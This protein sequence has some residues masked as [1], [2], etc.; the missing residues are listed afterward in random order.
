MAE[1]VAVEA[2]DAGADCAKDGSAGAVAAKGMVDDAGDGGAADADA[3]QGC[4]RV[5]VA[6]RVLFGAVE[7][8]DP[9]DGAGEGGVGDRGGE[10]ERGGMAAP[11]GGI[12][13]I[14]DEI[15]RDRV[16]G[17]A[18]FA[19]FADDVKAGE[20][21]AQRVHDHELRAAIGERLRI[22]G[23]AAGCDGFAVCGLVNCV[24]VAASS[25]VADDATG[26][27]GYGDARR[28]EQ[29]KRN[30]LVDGRGC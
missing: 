1:S 30:A 13:Q 2:C 25:H 14:R 5:E 8:I 16:A 19:F 17:E 21:A 18:H 29:R 3:D 6:E 22:G 12:A 24:E 10:G 11:C 9:H 20:E 27:L 4:D 23:I 7:G 26:A 28:Q 15:A